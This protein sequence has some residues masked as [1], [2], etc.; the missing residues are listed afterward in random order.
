MH[1]VRLSD[2]QNFPILLATPTPYWRLICL[3][4]ATPSKIQHNSMLEFVFSSTPAENFVSIQPCESKF[5]I[6]T[7]FI[8]NEFLCSKNCTLRFFRENDDKMSRFPPPANTEN[9]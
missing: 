1:A 6:G 3:Y 5:K 2:G 9:S 7:F 4:S 8:E